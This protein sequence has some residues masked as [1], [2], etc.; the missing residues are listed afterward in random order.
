MPYRLL[1]HSWQLVHICKSAPTFFSNAWPFRASI[2]DIAQVLLAGE[3]SAAVLEHTRACGA[4]SGI[5]ACFEPAARGETGL[6]T[7]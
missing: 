5:L 3:T 4:A 6:S 2:E 7:R 1:S